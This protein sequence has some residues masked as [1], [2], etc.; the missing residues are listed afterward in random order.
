M[1][2]KDTAARR[3]ASLSGYATPNTTYQAMVG[4]IF[5]ESPATGLTITQMHPVRYFVRRK[6]AGTK[7]QYSPVAI[8]ESFSLPLSLGISYKSDLTAIDGSARA[9]FYCVVY[10]SY[11][12]RTIETPI[13]IDFGL[14][15]DWTR[16]TATLSSVLGPVQGY[17]AFIEVYNATGN[18]YFDNVN[19]THDSEN[20]A[21]DPGCNNISQSFTRAFFQVARAWVP[22]DVVEGVDFG[23]IYYNE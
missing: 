16:E 20:W 13:S 6:V 17:S 19:I 2:V 9:R 12:G 23:S 3:R 14:S 8:T 1:F 5:V 10:S 11:Q 7:S 15:D 4:R 21:R 18:L 22:V